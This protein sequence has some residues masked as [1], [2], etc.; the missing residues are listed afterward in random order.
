MYKLLLPIYQEKNQW[1][2]VCNIY[3]FKYVNISITTDIKNSTVKL[4]FFI[5][6]FDFDE[7]LLY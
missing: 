3:T 5:V 6:K 1:G 4:I 7:L 2:A